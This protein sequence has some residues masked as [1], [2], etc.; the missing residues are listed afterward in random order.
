MSQ[1]EHAACWDLIPG[2]QAGELS[3]EDC[4]RVDAHV[5]ECDD[6]ASQL[7]EVQAVEI[8]PSPKE[9]LRERLLRSLP[10]PRRHPLALRGFVACAATLFLGIVGYIFAGMDEPQ[11]L[12][13]ADAAMEQVLAVAA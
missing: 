3:P 5:Q 7:E 1:D 11:H 10:E 12:M 13:A 6:C 2:Y 8:E 9:R 4:A